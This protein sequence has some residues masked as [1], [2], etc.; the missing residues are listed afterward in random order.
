MGGITKKYVLGFLYS[1]DKKQVA[2][3]I[4]NPTR[5]DQQWQKGRYNGIGGGIE[6]AET[7]RVAI[8]REFEEE[9]GKKVTA[10]IQFARMGGM[11]WEVYC[12]AGMSET[13][14]DLKTRTRE[15]VIVCA[16]DE[17]VINPLVIPNLRWLIPMGAESLTVAS[18]PRAEVFY[19]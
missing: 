10:W 6:N 8:E 7:P 14:A 12:F 18:G 13:L 11:G 3:I 16:V 4:K 15:K 19:T 2:L 9:T 17:A 1:E 5:P